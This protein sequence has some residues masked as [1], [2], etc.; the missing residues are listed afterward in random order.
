M[1]RIMQSSAFRSA[2]RLLSLALR[3]NP[4]VRAAIIGSAIKSGRARRYR[5]R[6]SRPGGHSSTSY[7]S[8]K[9]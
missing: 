3:S 2:L 9:S 1:I 4:V 7:R 6:Q 5:M 8:A